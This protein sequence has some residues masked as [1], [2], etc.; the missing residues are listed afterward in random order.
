MCLQMLGT[1]HVTSGMTDVVPIALNFG[2]EAAKKFELGKKLHPED[3]PFSAEFW[4]SWFDHWGDPGHV[5]RDPEEY[6]SELDDILRIGGSANIYMAC[7][8]TQFGFRGGANQKPGEA[9]L[10]DAASYDFDAPVAEYG[11]I[12]PKYAALKKVIRKYRPET[13]DETPENPPKA[14]YGK[15]DFTGTAKLFDNLEN[16]SRP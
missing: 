16:I 15:I 5:V 8:G 10:P 7:G 9:Y 3:P 2:F 11:D 12:M 6:A 1:S 14:A 4:G 13:P